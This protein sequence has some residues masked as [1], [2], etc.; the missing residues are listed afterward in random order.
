MRLP[1][2][3]ALRGPLVAVAAFAVLP[4][5]VTCGPRAT[6]SVPTPFGTPETLRPVASATPTP[7]FLAQGLTFSGT[8]SG[9]MSQSVVRTCSTDRGAFHLVIAAG[10]GTDPVV[11][12]VSVPT[13]SFRGTGTYDLKGSPGGAQAPTVA[14]RTSALAYTSAGGSGSL[15]VDGEHLSGSLQADLIGGPGGA[16][17]DHV[18]VNGT[19]RCNPPG[20]SAGG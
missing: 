14:V 3:A 1:D 12:D 13:G 2:P 18:R 4:L 16:G 5:V 10:E 17:S 8:I 7:S 11:I 6:R 9:L 19:W 15:T 20:S